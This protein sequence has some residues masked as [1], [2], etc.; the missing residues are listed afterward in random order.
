MK[1]FRQ[2]IRE[3]IP[4]IIGI[5]IALVINNWNEDRKDKLYLNL[6]LSSIEEELA[7][8][9]ADIKKS[10]PKQQLLLDSLGRYLNDETVTLVDIVKKAGGIHGPVIKNYSWKA[11]ANTRIELIEYEKLSAFIEMD[12]TKKNLE[13]KREKVL[14]FLFD[15]LKSTSQEKKEV[16]LMLLTDI[17]WTEKTLES[18]IS[19]LIE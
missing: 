5:L 11:L 12:E 10:I 7:E 17:M 1:Q 9:K 18:E 4:V 19:E 16:F 14:D 6:I 2:I 3:I 15:H 8:S 13:L